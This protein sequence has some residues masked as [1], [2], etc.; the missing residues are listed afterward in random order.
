[1]APKS[2][3]KHDGTQE[4]CAVTPENNLG[5]TTFRNSESVL[6]GQWTLAFT[7]SKYAI[8]R[9]KEDCFLVSFVYLSH[10]SLNVRQ[11]PLWLLCLLAPQRSQWSA[12]FGFRDWKPTLYRYSG[13]SHLGCITECGFDISPQRSGG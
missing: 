10:S 1:M 4:F 5:I 7:R 8:C 13:Q 3:A 6:L 12:F 2:V 11:L 9:P